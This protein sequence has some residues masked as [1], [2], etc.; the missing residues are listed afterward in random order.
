MASSPVT[1]VSVSPTS[2]CY[3]TLSSSSSSSNN[4]NNNNNNNNSRNVGSSDSSSG[5]YG[6]AKTENAKSTS[7]NMQTA[8]TVLTSDMTSETIT[9][10]PLKN[11]NDHGIDSASSGA[12]KLSR[13]GDGSLTKVEANST[14]GVGQQG[15]QAGPEVSGTGIGE[16]TSS[17]PSSG[18][19]LRNNEEESD[20][21]QLEI[22]VD[23]LLDPTNPIPIANT[24]VVRPMLTCDIIERV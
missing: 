11:N 19:A 4:N 20:D 13:Y 9:K 3:D 12:K 15:T 7:P 14:T 17:I 22:F 23:A 21:E 24:R 2:C 6:R 1:V 10:R 18:S 5:S 8:A 16:P